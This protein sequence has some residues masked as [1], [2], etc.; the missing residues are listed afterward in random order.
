MY[1]VSVNSYNYLDISLEEVCG[2]LERICSR[3]VVKVYQTVAAQFHAF[4]MHNPL[5]DVCCCFAVEVVRHQFACFIDLYQ[6]HCALFLTDI[7]RPL[8]CLL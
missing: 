8:L 6:Q 4:H 2:L 7:M 5:S 1:F 3:D